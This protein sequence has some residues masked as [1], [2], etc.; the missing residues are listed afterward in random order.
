VPDLAHW[1]VFFSATIVVLLIPGPSVMY[2]VARGIDSG[3]RAAVYS[4]AGLALGELFQV[5]CTAVGLSALLAS[6]LLLFTIVKYAGAAYLMAM[7]VCRILENSAP[8]LGGSTSG[9]R[10]SRTTSSRSFVFQGLFALNPKTA[11]FFLALFPQ[12]VAQNRGPAWLQIFFFGCAFVFLGFITNAIFGC[13]GG[14]LLGSLARTNNRFQST[15][16]YV[17]GVTLI[18][19]GVAGALTPIG[20][21]LLT[22]NRLTAFSNGKSASHQEITH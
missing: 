15:A 2:A 13:L 16:R 18:A 1:S 17:G 6:S 8:V 12:F 3:R 11:L 20:C 14:K 5:L 4:C 21:L 10:A 19:L 22:H 9:E 7:G